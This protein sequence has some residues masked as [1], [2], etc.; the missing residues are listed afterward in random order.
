MNRAA[1]RRRRVTA[2]EKVLPPAVEVRARMAEIQKTLTDFDL[3][4]RISADETGIFFG[5]PPKNQYIP[6]SATRATAPESNDK[7]RF[8]ALLWG[9][10]A[11]WMGPSFNTIKMN[12]KGADLSSSR[13][14]QNLQKE[15]GFR[16]SDG[17]ELRIWTRNLTLTVKGKMVTTDYVRPYLIHLETVTIITVQRKAWMDTVGI[18]MWADVQLGPFYATKRGKCCVVWDNCGPHK[19]AA[20]TEVFKGWGITSEALPPKM[21]DILQAMDLI[22]NGPVK[23]GIRRARVTALFN[24]FQSWKIKRLQHIAARNTSLPPEFTPPK[25]RRRQRAC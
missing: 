4:E 1:L 14:L 18:C 7:A 16:D 12:V 21:T 24:F 25:P 9:V 17:W 22:V 20:V 5:A 11:G 8:T 13:V 10:A 23:A 15:A 19:V 2:S 3:E 6:L